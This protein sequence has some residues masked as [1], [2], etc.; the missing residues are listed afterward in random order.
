MKQRMQ[1]T[2]LV[3]DETQIIQRAISGEKQAFGLLYEKYSNAILRYLFFRLASHEEAEDMT[4]SVF[5]KAW[6]A[7]PS[8]K[9]LKKDLN[10]RA[11]LYR[12]AHNS[13]VDF[14]RAHKEELSIDAIGELPSRTLIPEKATEQIES[15]VELTCAIRQLDEISLQV[16]MNRFI[17]GLDHRETAQILGLGE[18]NI[19]VIQ[20]RALK[21]LKEILGDT[22]E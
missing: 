8:L 18:G 11:W 13:L 6:E 7:L 1:D 16:I 9:H 17:A 20:F 3:N 22:H 12:I 4:E 21:K 14:L 10:F 5:I 15:K 19:R 2:Q